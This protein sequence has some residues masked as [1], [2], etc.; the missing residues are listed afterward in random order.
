MKSDLQ[1]VSR[2]ALWNDKDAFNKLVL[3][4]QSPVRRFLYNL[5]KGDV[6]I[7]EDL[8]QDTF[9]KAW[10]HIKSFRA[11]SKFSTWLYRIAYRTFY[12]YANKKERDKVFLVN[13][14]ADTT[15]NNFHALASDMDFLTLLGYLTINERTVC[16]LYFMEDLTVK[17]IA[18]IMGIPI[19][20]VKSHL[21]RS[22]KKLVN[23]LD[24]TFKI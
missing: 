11:A 17:N 2:A 5:C 9:L 15:Y 3:R 8:S 21:H 23:I 4:Y 1:L 19:G 14:E 22:K 13:I 18:K 12:D 20:T 16:L 24:K 7:A 6:K 10:L